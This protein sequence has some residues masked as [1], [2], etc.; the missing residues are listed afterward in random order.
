MNI[1][2]GDRISRSLRW[3]IC[4]AVLVVLT[5]SV[6]AQVRGGRGWH[7]GGGHGWRGGGHGW[8]GGGHGWHGG[9]WHGGRDHWG[10]SVGVGLGLGLWDLGFYPYYRY[11][12]YWPRYSYPVG[13]Y[14]SYPAYGYNYAY[15]VP[16]VTAPAVT[17]TPPSDPPAPASTVP[18]ASTSSATP[19]T[20]MT[21]ANRLF[22]R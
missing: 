7:G 10:V 3:M 13:F 11:G 20:T 1:S 8:H 19:V 18:T 9:G 16:S 12:G 22:G 4:L 15:T 2:T 21:S 5:T 17:P 14:G 6:L